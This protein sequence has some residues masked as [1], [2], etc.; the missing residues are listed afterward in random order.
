L[1]LKKKVSK[2]SKTL[3]LGKFKNKI[4]LITHSRLE[5]KDFEIDPNLSNRIVEGI[6]SFGT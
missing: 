2:S 4:I 5:P 6:L 1:A 3:N